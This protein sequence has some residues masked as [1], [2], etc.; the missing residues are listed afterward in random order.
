MGFQKGNQH[1]AKSKRGKDI[2]KQKVK[3]YLT[4]FVDEYLIEKLRE[5]FAEITAKERLDVITKLMPYI[6]PKLNSNDVKVDA[7]DKVIEIVHIDAAK[8]K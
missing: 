2:V 5:D 3:Q 7:S 1:G 8:E 6:M 4:E